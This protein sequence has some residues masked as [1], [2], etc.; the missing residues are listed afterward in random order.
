[1]K[2]IVIAAIIC[3]LVLVAVLAA[4]TKAPNDL[5]SERYT[6]LAAD[7]SYAAASGESIRPSE[8]KGEGDGGFSLLLSEKRT[9]NSALI[10]ASGDATFTLSADGEVFYSGGSGYAV[11]Q[12]VSADKIDISVK[13]EG[14][15]SVDSLGLYYAP[16]QSEKMTVF[17]D[18]EK[19]LA[20]GYQSSYFDNAERVILRAGLAYD[21]YGAVSF[22]EGEGYF[23]SAVSALKALLLSSK[24]PSAAIVAQADVVDSAEA[25]GLPDIAHMRYS[26]L[27][28]SARATAANLLSAAGKFGLQGIHLDIADEDAQATTIYYLGDFAEKFKSISSSS[29]LLVSM[30]LNG[31]F[32]RSEDTSAFFAKIFRDNM[33]GVNFLDGILLSP[34]EISLDGAAEFCL[35]SSSFQTILRIDCSQSNA[36]QAAAFASDCGASV[37]LDAPDEKVLSAL[38]TIFSR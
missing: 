12:S 28:T 21:P 24:S 19:L 8:R 18:A 23:A 17:A 29:Q 6:D 37:A 7:A 36:D 22:K 1:M 14:K 15:W 20:G 31:A 30:R 33:T 32:K 38:D 34:D 9:F 2:K 26:A 16:A 3:L 13:S 10:G 5:L 25:S 4:C 35:L 11:F 27:R